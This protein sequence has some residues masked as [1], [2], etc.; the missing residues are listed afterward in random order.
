MINLLI[1][2]QNVLT[3]ILSYA[4][5]NTLPRKNFK[6]VSSQGAKYLFHFLM[7]PHEIMFVFRR[8]CACIETLFFS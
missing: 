1:Y 8:N 5:T 3:S 7:H 4:R 6:Q 2:T